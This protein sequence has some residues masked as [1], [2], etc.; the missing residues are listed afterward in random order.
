MMLQQQS[1]GIS[2]GGGGD[3]NLNTIGFNQGTN[4]R[5]LFNR[6]PQAFT[7]LINNPKLS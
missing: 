6:R 4:A 2:T 3:G 5:N 1:P 7:N